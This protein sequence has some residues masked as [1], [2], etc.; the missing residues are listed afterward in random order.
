MNNR[1]NNTWGFSKKT[2]NRRVNKNTPQVEAADAV[3]VVAENSIE[4]VQVV[5]CVDVV[6]T[7]SNSSSEIESVSGVNADE[8]VQTEN[9]TIQMNSSFQ[10]NLAS[11]AVNNN[12]TAT[13]LN[14][15]LS[16]LKP[17]FPDLPKDSR[18]LLQT[19]KKK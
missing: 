8:D 2:L 14:Q 7:I 6:T 11:W 9:D 15:L 17:S 1:F 3:I 18:T 16:L 19:Q 10:V 5:E 13:A 12:I 4:T